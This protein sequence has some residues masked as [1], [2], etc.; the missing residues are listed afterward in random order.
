QTDFLSQL[1]REPLRFSEGNISV[2]VT[3]S[4]EAA[5]LKPLARAEP[6]W[7]M[8]Y[9]LS[10]EAGP[11]RDPALYTLFDELTQRDAEK[12]KIYPC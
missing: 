7:V 3:R 12:A 4:L 1:D 10:H 9:L 6:E 8:N 11:K 2:L 5:A